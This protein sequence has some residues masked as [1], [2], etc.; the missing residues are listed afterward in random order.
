[1]SEPTK[2][3]FTVDL[4]EIDRQLRRA[5]AS[6][7]SQTAGQPGVPAGEQTPA[8][9]PE[10]PF[11]DFPS[12]FPSPS[13]HTGAGYPAADAPGI[14]PAPLL[15]PPYQPVSAPSPASQ[16]AAPKN[17]FASAGQGSDPLQEL[18][19]IVGQEDP[20]QNILGQKQA[21]GQHRPV[22][23]PFA[24][25]LPP[26]QQAYDPAPVSYPQDSYSAA[27]ASADPDSLA[28]YLK[29]EGDTLSAGLSAQAPASSP[30]PTYSRQEEQPPVAEDLDEVASRSRYHGEPQPAGEGFDPN[31]FSTN[32]QPPQPDYGDYAPSFADPKLGYQPG[33]Y[34]MGD[35]EFAPPRKSSKKY[36]LFGGVA[37]IC[38]IGLAAGYAMMGNEGGGEPPLVTASDEPT[39]VPPETPGGKEF[40]DQNKQIYAGGAKEGDTQVVNREEQPVDVNQATGRSSLAAGEFGEPRRVRTVAVR[41]DGTIIGAETASL[42]NSTSAPSAPAA[43]VMQMPEAESPRTSSANTAAST[44]APTTTPPEPVQQVAPAAPPP[45]VRPPQQAAAPR[46]Q[47]ASVQT[48]PAASSGGGAYA[49]QFG[50]SGSEAE[51]QNRFNRLQGQYPSVLGGVAASIRQAEVNGRTIFR[52]RSTGMSREESENLCNSLKAAGGDCYVARN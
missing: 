50:V 34:E 6:P 11:F 18:A 40:P 13:G 41:P 3:R 49:V 15:P 8:V 24:S 48:P 47:T 28:E 30:Y 43:P 42:S 2:P 4:D 23:D 10:D 51:G 17:V 7:T 45:P 33:Y 12:S 1:M 14:E 19:R 29:M 20:F 36:Y 21:P 5:A 37:A 32:Y 26:Q 25:S 38:L 39:K 44:P 35:E 52:I 27:P 31:A 46:Q 22:Q 16:P 9:P